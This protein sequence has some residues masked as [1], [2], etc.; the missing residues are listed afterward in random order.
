MT[1]FLGQM[2][3]SAP[4]RRQGRASEANVRRPY[5]MRCLPS[6]YTRRG[7]DLPQCAIVR[8]EVRKRGVVELE[9][10]K[11]DRYVEVWL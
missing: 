3:Q 7:L 8:E 9:I 5:I 6:S 2:S 11:V 1:G 4:T 10:G